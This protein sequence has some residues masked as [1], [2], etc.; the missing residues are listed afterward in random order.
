[1]RDIVVGDSECQIDLAQLLDLRSIAVIGASEDQT[2]FGGRLFKNLLRHGFDGTVYPINAG[3]SQLFDIPAYPDLASLPG[4][5]DA[6]A[7]ALP[8]HLVKDQVI[9][10][11]KLGVK[12]GII[13]SSGFS[14]AGDE[15]KQLEEEIV[16]IA[17]SHGMRLIGPNCLGVISPEKGF[18]LCSSPI[19]DRESLPKRSIG[20][21][22]QSGALMTT[23][24]DKAWS[25]G[26]GF[27]HGFSVGNQAD[28]DVCD[29]IDFLVKDKAT[30]VICA[31]I[32]GVK[33]AGRF[34][35]SAN[36]ARAANKPLLIVKAG[37]SQAG[38]EAAFSHT[39]SIAGDAA[40]FAA[41]CREQGALVIDDINTML[42]VASMLASQPRRP[43]SRV[44]IVTPSGGG[45]ALAADALSEASLELAQLGDKAHE[46]LTA[47]Y[48]PGQIKNPLDFG[49]R[50]GRDETASAEATA[51]A[52][53]QDPDVDAVLCV[54][55]MAPVPWQLQVVESQAKMAKEHGKPVIVAIDAGRTSDP[56]RERL[57]A[58]DIPYTNSTADAVKTLVHVK[59]WGDMRQASPAVR[60][61]SCPVHI[62]ALA[63][64]QYD[65]H[66]SKALLSTYG[67]PVN[68]G[69]MAMSADEAAITAVRLGFPIV[70]KVVS[71]DIVHKSDVGGVIVGLNT[72]DDVR[73]A[74]ATLLSNVNERQPD[75]KIEG[76][77][78][79]RM[80]SGHL[81]VIVGAR[82]DEAFGPVIL[83][84]AG[85]VLVE[86]LPDKYLATAP[87][88]AE[89][90]R[91]GL[92]TLTI[93][94]LLEGYR[95]KKV[96]VD[97]LVDI[98]VRL[99]WLMHDLKEYNVEIDINPVLVGADHATAVDA[100]LLIT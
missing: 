64:G 27:T 69:A 97:A 85:G 76:V 71:P 5:P 94:K 6:F 26:G 36:A 30:N 92:Q 28:L 80:L 48:P 7:L 2:K 46:I 52:I 75:A 23:A 96:A 43:I 54:T 24:F 74:F 38:Q 66:Q 61:D 86:L 53:Q 16:A 29:F 56:V 62:G 11:A 41:A 63:A 90:V 20:F 89:A 42:S 50:L 32:E 67:I 40:V 93:W 51:L 82:T 8:S 14:D 49:T 19:L 81:E 13:I 4:V 65:E 44:A 25:T 31:Y 34:L 15:G 33:D 95:G 87:L 77:L 88:S 59:Q 72:Q 73:T 84:G 21:V 35:I 12:L 47:Y 99:G 1:M 17:R 60:P 91:Q 78:V 3:R 79:Q 18:V 37:R 39:A 68:E 58:L 22:S 100:R 55:A 10:A 70:L 83:F 45:G 57:A 9:A 98:I